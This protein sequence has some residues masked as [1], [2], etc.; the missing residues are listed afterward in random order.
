VVK[1]DWIFLI[2]NVSNDEIKNL[3]NKT[4][5]SE[6]LVRVLY[7]R[8]FQNIND[9]QK[10][11]LNKAEEH[12]PNLLSDISKAKKRIENAIALNQKIIIYGDY[13]A[14]GV[15]STAILFLLL[16][17]YTK[18]LSYFIPDRF[19]DG[20]GPNLKQ[21]KRIINEKNNL[22]IT[23]DNGISGNEA[24]QLAKD[25][26]I[27]TI[28]F[29]HH[30]LPSELPN[31]YAIVHPL[32]SPEY[33]FK[34]LSAAG[35]AY[36]FAKYY[37]DSDFSELATIGEVADV[38]PLIDEN[39]KI[40]LKGIEKINRGFNKGIQ[41]LI[42][43]S[44][45]KSP[46]NARS[47]GFQ[48]APRINSF[49]R[50]NDANLAMELLITDD[51]NRARELALFA[52][53]LNSQRQNEVNN[54]YK[55]AKT[56]VENQIN[57]PFLIIVGDN[58]S[59]GIIGLL[60]G[61]IT[62]QYNRPSIVFSKANGILKGSGRS[63]EDFDI[64]QRLN[65]KK[66]LF[67]SMGGHKQ[68]AGMSIHEDNFN[69]LVDY[70]KKSNYIVKK[71]KIII[72]AEIKENEFTVDNFHELQKLE[73]FGNQNPEPILLIEN[74]IIEQKKIIG[75]KKNTS[76]IKLET[77]NVDILIFNDDSPD[78]LEHSNVNIIGKLAV[79]EWNNQSTSQFLAE[80][81]TANNKLPE[82]TIF[83]NYYR[84]V[85]KTPQEYD[86]N[87][88]IQ[89]VFLELNFVKIE[90]GFIFTN[91]NAGSKSL[92]KSTIYQKRVKNDN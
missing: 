4:G 14:D 51:T 21:Y 13:D 19:N 89:N 16:K 84:K 20:Y 43:I 48:I 47:I 33:P 73:P 58:W 22:I 18:N 2:K 7:N 8:G 26:G 65:E 30:Q 15:T 49:G 60:A 69:Q 74:E 28:I 85:F 91:K 67:I 59:E 44:K 23:I 87:N 36:K 70:L 29:D 40:V 50:M 39:K 41:E 71:K 68:A 80:D 61:K 35:I 75:A 78:I 45:I 54:L 31:A 86:Q 81:Y 6:L 77:S 37:D 64:F 90:N 9:I 57:D 56:Q 32:H 5:F 88:F 82:K 24:I 55:I 11:V 92:I 25:N 66:D 27:D 63:T 52:N 46:I 34:D 76:K 38:M 1:Y 10:E 12:N 42:K 79:N 62:Q 53:Q 3:A 72:D 17:K 83:N